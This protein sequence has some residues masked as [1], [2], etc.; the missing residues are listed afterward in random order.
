M[1]FR[2][3]LYFSFAAHMLVFSSAIAVAQYAGGMFH[4]SPRSI[5]VTLVSPGSG[6]G[7]GNGSVPRQE[8][9]AGEAPQQRSEEPLDEQPRLSPRDP[10]IDRTAAPATPTVTPA[11]G[12]NENSSDGSKSAVSR[13][14][15]QVGN[16]SGSEKQGFIPPAQWAVIEA[17]IERSKTYP[18][19]ARERGIEGIVRLRFRLAP[20][21]AVEKIEIIESSGS[22]L[23]D[24]ASIRS[25]YR[26]A[27]MPFV[28]GWVEVPMVYVLK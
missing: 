19:L 26:A 4:A 25:V 15:G 2:N 12:S 3:S 6:A 10:P 22:E 18:R 8:V 7:T 20:S 21:G 16:G 5:L 1:T 24:S 13:T 28:H 17:A 23:L 27:P 11:A 9:R 14:E